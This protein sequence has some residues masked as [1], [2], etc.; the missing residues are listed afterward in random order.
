MGLEPTRPLGH[1]FL[2]PACLPFH[3]LAYLYYPTICTGGPLSCYDADAI[4]KATLSRRSSPAD[5]FDK[6]SLNLVYPRRERTIAAFIK[7]ST[8][9]N[10][11]Q[12]TSVARAGSRGGSSA[13]W[14]KSKRLESI[15][16]ENST[17]FWTSGPRERLIR[18]G[19]L[20]NSCAICGLPP[21]WQGQPL[22]MILDHS[23]G[24]R[25]DNRVENLR[26]LCPNCN[27]QQPTFAGKNKGRYP[28]D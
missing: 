1:R 21:S 23:N 7:K 5:P 6:F 24:N 8:A 9:S 22:V 20:V 28:M 14:A 26:L 2:K 16:I 18:E 27:S 12:V 3:H 19:R 11:I 17:C 4:R 10:S 15:L 13:S 25:S